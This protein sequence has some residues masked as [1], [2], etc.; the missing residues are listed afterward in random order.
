MTIFSDTVEVITCL[1]NGVNYVITVFEDILFKQLSKFYK[2]NLPVVKRR[3]LEKD[4]IQQEHILKP[5]RTSIR[6]LLNFGNS[7]STIFRE[8]PQMHSN[9]ITSNFIA[10]R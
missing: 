7:E 9:F 10:H 2:L 4:L 5:S 1:T 6:T 8:V 3:L